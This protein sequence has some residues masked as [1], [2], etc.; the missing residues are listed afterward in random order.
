MQE[1]RMK[2]AVLGSGNIGG[3][4]G[5]K[6]AK[7]GHQ[8]V[9]GSRDPGSEKIQ[10]LLALAGENA[11]AAD[12]AQAIVSSRVVLFAIPSAG[13][14]M[15]ARENSPALDGKLLIDATNNFGAAVVN[16]LATLQRYA[17][18]AALFRAFNALGWENF[19]NPVYGETAVDLFYCGQ[20]GEARISMEQLIGDIGLRP[21][22]VGGLELAPV[23]DALGSLWVT[24]AFRQGWGRGIALK[25]VQR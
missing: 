4:L 5:Q 9:F 15:V 21:V 8:V 11:S 23:I 2:I 18:K 6:W 17:P 12:T 25:L 19:A 7:A 3:T 16:N 20:E 13:V 22:Y 14:E 1:I 10:Q 24:L